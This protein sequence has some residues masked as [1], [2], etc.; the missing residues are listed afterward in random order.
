[1][2][3]ISQFRIA[4]LSTKRLMT[5]AIISSCTFSSMNRCPSSF[6]KDSSDSHWTR[7]NSTS[8]W[9]SVIRPGWRLCCS[10]ALHFFTISLASTTS[11]HL[12]SQGDLSGMFPS[13]SDSKHIEHVI[14]VAIS[15]VQYQQSVHSS[16]APIERIFL[17]TTSQSHYNHPCFWTHAR[18]VASGWTFNEW[19]SAKQSPLAAL[20]QLAASGF[21]SGSPNLALP[22]SP[23]FTIAGIN[24]SDVISRSIF[25]ALMFNALFA[26][27]AEDVFEAWSAIEI[28][29]ADK[30]QA[31]NPF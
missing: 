25:N 28:S 17:H 21:A 7:H 23:F 27:E 22:V 16:I 1:M 3:T 5:T 24:L 14:R 8:R 6:L 2:S 13:K 26:N 18:Y 12:V 30:H 20:I 31:G 4:S 11:T 19:Q 15:L 9:P 10:M 29:H